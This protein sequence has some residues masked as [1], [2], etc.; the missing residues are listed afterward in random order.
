MSSIP[1][2]DLGDFDGTN[3]FVRTSGFVNWIDD[4]STRKPFQRVGLG[5][6][7]VDGYVVCTVW[8]DD[9]DLEKGVGYRFGGVDGVWDAGGEVQL[10]LGDSSWAEEFW[11][12]E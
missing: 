2:V 3:G 5:A 6:E 9:I 8:T 10:K 12:P 11:R 7:S 1:R 4:V